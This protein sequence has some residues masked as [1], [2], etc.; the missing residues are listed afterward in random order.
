MS[1]LTE[2]LTVTADDTLDGIIRTVRVVWRL[3][4]NLLLDR[5]DILERHLSV[6]K[7]FLRKFLIYNELTLSVTYSDSMKITY[8]KALEPRRIGSRYTGCN[9]LRDMAVDIVTEECR[10]VLC[11]LTETAV[12]KKTRLHKSLESVADAENKTTTVDKRVDSIRYILVVQHVGNKLTA[13]VR[14]VSRRESA[15]EHQDMTL[16]DILL[17]FRDRTEDIIFCEIAEYA[18]T[19]L[20]TGIA[21]SLC[22]V[23]VTVCTREYREICYRCLYRLTLIFKV[24]LLRL[25]RLHALQ[26]CWSDLLVVSLCCIRINLGESCRVHV[27]KFEDIELLAVDDEFAFLTVCNL[28]NKDCVRIIK[29]AFRLDED[30]SV[31]V[32]EQFLLVV[33]NLCIK[34]VTERHLADCLCKASESKSIS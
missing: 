15:A 23:I 13:S 11:H 27:H 4:R 3:H 32:V 30:R 21:P 31:S 16:V 34:T 14:F 8:G 7:E 1:H 9:H 20:G 18:H 29:L 19:H 17:H 25:E 6:S 28:S 33:F 10:A 22:R 24:S 12:W 2:N 5:I 26:A